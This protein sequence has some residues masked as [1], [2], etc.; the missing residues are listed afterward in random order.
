MAVVFAGN[1]LAG[2]TSGTPVTGAPLTIACW[3]QLSV[4]T[5]ENVLVSL[6]DGTATNQFY[7]AASGGT[8]GDPV[9]FIT[10]ATTA[11]N[12]ATSTGYSANTWH[13]ACGIE[14]S[15][16]SRAAYIDGGSK[17]TNTTS[18]TPAGI[19]R[20][21]FCV[22]G[23][24]T[25]TNSSKT[26]AEVGIW[27]VALTDAE[28]ATLAA[29]VSPRLMR[30]ANLVFYAPLIT[31]NAP[32]IDLYGRTL[33]N[34]ASPTAAVHPRIIYPARWWSPPLTPTAGALTGSLAK[35]LADVTA[36]SASKLAI[37]GTTAA[38]LADTTASSAATLAIAGTLTATLA[39]ATLSSEGSIAADAIE[40]SL[41]STLAD[42][43]ASSAAALAIAGT[44][45]STLDATTA[46]SA[47]LFGGPF[48]ADVDVTLAA[49]TSA[50]VGDIAAPAVEPPAP[51]TGTIY[52]NTMAGRVRATRQQIKWLEDYLFRSD[53]A[54]KR[55]RKR[56]HLPEEVET[57]DAAASAAVLLSG[58]ED[59]TLAQ[60][61]AARE[62]WA[63][64]RAEA[65]RR[66]A[67]EE[68]ALIRA[69]ITH[70]KQLEAE[71]KAEAERR[72]FEEDEE[73]AVMLLLAAL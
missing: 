18:R 11:N 71:Q 54:L 72:A 10:Q 28:V 33:A 13:H 9:R 3:F 1:T 55:K 38:T 43:T 6:S 32:Q 8:G 47:A 21:N 53:K 14:A 63:A 61:G 12:A 65:A 27:N 25:T 49:V 62:V 23:A 37:A 56:K 45:A 30:P 26:L 16:T 51:A 48:D 50:A 52:G 17:G 4:T 58:A 42:V 57:D 5:L 20:V 68:M 19:D 39:D 36:T 22:N 44:L 24:G 2:P 31:T 29:G 7:L 34:S 69:V 46:T 66:K 15:A 60:L 67:D 70:L 59:A 41:A 35:T 64:A 40:G 73:E